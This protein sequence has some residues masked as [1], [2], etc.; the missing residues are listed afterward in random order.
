VQIVGYI[1]TNKVV[2]RLRTYKSN[3]LRRVTRMNNNKMPKIMTYY[4]LMDE[5]DLE[6]LGREN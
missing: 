2:K 4:R 3:W 6:D 1:N 5:K